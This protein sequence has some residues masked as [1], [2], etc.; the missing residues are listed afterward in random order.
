VGELDLERALGESVAEG[1][2]TTGGGGKSHQI[3][4]C[5]KGE[6]EGGAR[7]GQGVRGGGKSG[8]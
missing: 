7:K 5:R 6:A 8:K 1:P 3:V 2:A 4:D